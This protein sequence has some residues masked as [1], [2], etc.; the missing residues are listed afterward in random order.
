MT[1]NL[2]R[3]LP[4]AVGVVIVLVATAAPASAA[5]F[6]VTYEAGYYTGAPDVPVEHSASAQF[7]LP[8]IACKAGQNAA[9]DPI[10]DVQGSAPTAVSAGVRLKCV[11]GK[12]TYQPQ[13]YVNGTRTFPALAVKAGDTISESATETST[14]SVVAL[15]DVTT[16]KSASKSGGGG[17]DTYCEITMARVT[18]TPT[19]TTNQPIPNFGQLTFT[20]SKI[21]GKA[22]G[23]SNW[24]SND[25]YS[26]TVNPPPSSAHLLI[27]VSN[28]SA[29]GTK[30]TATF[31]ASS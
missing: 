3:I 9:V 2:R 7:K 5:A 19:S 27:S 6:K 10:V 31:K 29:G 30:F 28:L 16:G 12:A 17:K 14:H 8:A 15:H 23:S 1:K 11:A 26:G 24:G 25:M 13:L 18:T 20:N 22:V 21:S 4:A